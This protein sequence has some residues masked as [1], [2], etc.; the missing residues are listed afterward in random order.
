MSFISKMDL[1]VFIHLI[2]LFVVNIIF[3]F[4]GIISNILVIVSF[5]KSSHLRKKLCHFLMLVLSCFDLLA[6]VTNQAGTLLY[7]IF[8]LKEDYHLLLKMA[9]FL[10]FCDAFFG[11]S[12]C[13]LLV[14]C[15]ERYLGAY[16]PFFHRTS[17]TRRRLL[18][19]LVI[20]SSSHIISYVL[21]ANDMIISWTIV[22]IIDT[23]A[24]LPPLL[25]LNFKLFKI[26]R[27]VRRRNATSP[28]VRSTV[29]FKSISTCLLVVL[30]LSALTI[31]CSVYIVFDTI[32]ENKQATSVR[33]SLIWST[34]IYTMNCTSN[35]LIFFWKNKVLRTEGKKLLKTLKDRL[36]GS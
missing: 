12:F 18:T 23:I 5:W 11:L 31:A 26:S 20:L 16:Y 24:I 3:T 34:T 27:K 29:N 4:S 2:F 15:I 22:L 33:L 17:V 6:V 9:I 19:L 36:V 32:S 28:E 30:C 7:L 35:S 21:S 14:M 25:Y 8:W 10:H 1:N 13:V